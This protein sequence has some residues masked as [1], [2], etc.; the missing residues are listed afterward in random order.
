MKTKTLIFGHRGIPVK[1]PEN[2]LAGFKYAL[3]QQIDG[4]ELDVHLTKDQIPVVIH[5]ETL[6][7][8]TNGKGKIGDYSLNELKKFRLSDGER[9]PTLKEVLTLMAF[10]DVYL[11]LEFKTNVVS[12][13]GIEKIVLDLVNESKLKY[14]VIYSSFNVQT[15]RTC[16]EI[17]PNQNYN[18]LSAAKSIKHPKQFLLSEGFSG[19][20]TSHYQFAS[21]CQRSWTINK[22]YKAILLLNLGVSGIITDDFEKMTILRDKYQSRTKLHFLQNLRHLT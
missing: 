1:Y 14:P 5:D 10:R 20:H 3:N 12:Y 8:T 18:L 11:N 22:S 17:D 7:R 15:L 13:P 19:L 6:E 21:I 4:I 9:I 16:R 2:S